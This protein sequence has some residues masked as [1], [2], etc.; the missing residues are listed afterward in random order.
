MSFLLLRFRSVWSL[1]SLLL[2]AAVFSSMICAGRAQSLS[3]SIQG[4]VTD[5]SKAVVPGATVRAVTL[6]RLQPIPTACFNLATF[7]SIRTI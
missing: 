5:P 6:A 4:T 3:G 1:V 7:R 2:F